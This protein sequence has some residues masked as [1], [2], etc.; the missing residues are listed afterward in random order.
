MADTLEGTCEC[1]ASSTAGGVKTAVFHGELPQLKLVDPLGFDFR[2]RPD[3]P[4]VGAGVVVPG[5]IPP[6]PGG[7]HPDIGAYQ[8]DGEPW[9]AGCTGLVG[10]DEKL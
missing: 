5:I 6:A 8:H 10:C 9:T 7:K 4:L 2:P 3:S 1:N